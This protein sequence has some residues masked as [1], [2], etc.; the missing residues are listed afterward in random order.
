MRGAH[1]ECLLSAALVSTVM[2]VYGAIASCV[3]IT[4]TYPVE[5]LRGLMVLPILVFAI[6]CILCTGLAYMMF[7]SM[8]RKWCRRQPVVVSENYD[9][10][11]D[12]SQDDEIDD[13]EAGR[14]LVQRKA[15]AI[16]TIIDRAR[17]DDL[18]SVG[19]NSNDDDD[20][21]AICCE[22]VISEGQD[23]QVTLA[24][25]V[26]D[27]GNVTAHISICSRPVSRCPGCG[28]KFHTSCLCKALLFAST[29]PTCPMCRGKL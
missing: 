20:D 23:N 7:R 18:R 1:V 25:S 9:G 5:R 24:L 2:L 11:N 12:N 3:F 21:C 26:D 28:K 14:R 19:V 4:V 6:L 17:C 16:A 22:A 13:I 27:A 29:I 15:M 8:I 10:D